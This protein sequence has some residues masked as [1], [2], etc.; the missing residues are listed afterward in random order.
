M[1][2]SSILN[3]LSAVVFCLPLSLS[4]QGEPKVD[5]AREV[6]PIL[7]NYCFHCHG[8]DD[9]NRKGG[10]GKGLRLDQEDGALADI[11][12]KFAVVPN[13]P[14]KSEVIARLLSTDADEVMPAP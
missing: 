13:H 4:A 9:K 6:R 2:I 3:Q 7:S 11:G 10:D 12:G 14:E 1:R 5:F 8:P